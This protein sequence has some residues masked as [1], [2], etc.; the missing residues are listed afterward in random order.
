MKDKIKKEI[1][2]FNNKS[3]KEIYV[4]DKYWSYQE[5]KKKKGKLE[6]IIN[7]I[8]IAQIDATDL[9]T[10]CNSIKAKMV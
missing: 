9:Q 1:K 7:E 3:L 10:L 8:I 5:K 4:F 6:E 2:E